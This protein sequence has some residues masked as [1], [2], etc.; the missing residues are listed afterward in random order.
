MVLQN[1]SLRLLIQLLT[2]VSPSGCFHLQR[3]ELLFQQFIAMGG[4]SLLRQRPQIR[5]QR[6]FDLI[7]AE[8][9]AD[10]QSPTNKVQTLLAAVKAKSVGPLGRRYSVG[11]V[12]DGD[13]IPHATSFLSLGTPADVLEHFPGVRY[14]KK[15]MLGDCEADVRELRNHEH[16]TYEL[17]RLSG[18]DMAESAD[19]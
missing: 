14:C 18:N 10:S 19:Q 6:A 5:L 3:S 8:L 9:G 4:T 17:T 1:L 11:P 16:R 12:V 7:T 15:I 2:M 13:L